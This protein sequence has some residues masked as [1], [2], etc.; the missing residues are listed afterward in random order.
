MFA[1]FLNYFCVKCINW[2][3]KDNFK[4]TIEP[5]LYVCFCSTCINQPHYMT[6]SCTFCLSLILF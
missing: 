6:R 2:E 4:Q 1:N 5:I 3:R